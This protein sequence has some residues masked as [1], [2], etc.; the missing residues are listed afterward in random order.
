M[1]D[2]I[3]IV[4]DLDGTLVYDDTLYVLARKILREQPL[5]CLM[6]PIKL[7][8]GKAAMKQYMSSIN[9]ISAHTLN[10]NQSLIS[11]LKTEREQGRPVV[12]CTASNSH[13]AD[14]VAAHLGI[15]DAVIGSGE[16][17]NLSGQ[18]KAHELV[19]R[20]G[21]KNFDYNEVCRASL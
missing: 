4:V 5:K 17:I 9:Q 7:L 11:W 20:Y 16:K 8:N 1:S 14:A 13:T 15:F 12:L 21:D 10:Y 2:N 18:A 6:L 3:P 19:K